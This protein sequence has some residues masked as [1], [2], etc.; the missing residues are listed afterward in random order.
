[1]KTRQKTSVG[2]A[3]R[4]RKKGKAKLPRQSENALRGSFNLTGNYQGRVK[5]VKCCSKDDITGFLFNRYNITT[6]G[7]DV[8]VTGK[9]PSM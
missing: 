4:R 9:I 7:T 8:K 5:V 2:A 1:M 6:T 3:K